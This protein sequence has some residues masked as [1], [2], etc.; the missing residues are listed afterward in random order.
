M[1][2]PQ[3]SYLYI[4]LSE[5]GFADDEVTTLITNAF[6]RAIH[7]QCDVVGYDY[8]LLEKLID[9]NC[10]EMPSLLTN[11]RSQTTTKHFLMQVHNSIVDLLLMVGQLLYM[12]NVLYQRVPP[13][14]GC[15]VYSSVGGCT[16][17]RFYLVSKH[18]AKKPGYYHLTHQAIAH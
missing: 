3:Q 14:L 1:V 13:C 7:V 8:L 11:K 18:F 12:K 6:A 2:W 17:A 15:S 5:L 10:M 9:I 16:W 4:C